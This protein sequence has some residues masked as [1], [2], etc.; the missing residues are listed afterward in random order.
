MKT[1][2]FADRFLES[3]ETRHDGAAVCVGIDPVVGRLPDAIRP[4][5]DRGPQAALDAIYEFSVG[6]ID[7]VADHVPVVKMQSACFERYRSD[8]VEA[9]YSL[10]EEAHR[11]ELLVIMDAKRGDVSVSAEHYAA[12]FFAPSIEGDDPASADPLVRSAAGNQFDHGM[13][14]HPSNPDALT[15]NPY[16]GMDSIEPYCA[17]NRGIFA[18]VRTSNPG[19]DEIQSMRLEEE[20]STIAEYIARLVADKADQYLGESGYST[21]GAV[22][23][24]TKPSDMSRLRHLMPRSLFLVPGFGAQGGSPEDVRAAFNDDGRGALITA[25]RSVIYAFQ[26][27]ESDWSGAIA[28]AAESFANEI[29]AIIKQ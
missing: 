6:V 29:R 15:I 12:S 27:D 2:H 1:A 10:V 9:L 19:S 22:V 14:D 17:F 7:T 28:R 5:S 26:P 13:L 24:A 3:V 16:L 21:M 25:S 18:L 23:A 4:S 20:S 8:G 11:R